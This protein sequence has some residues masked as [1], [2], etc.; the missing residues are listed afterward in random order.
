MQTKDRVRY[1][2]H[3]QQDK[4]KRRTQPKRLATQ[5]MT[6]IETY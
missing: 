4:D 1:A 5:K 3:K 2:Y 6:K